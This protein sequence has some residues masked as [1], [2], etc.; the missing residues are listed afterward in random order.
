V[1]LCAY[2]GLTVTVSDGQ[3]AEE[4]IW[5]IIH[6]ESKVLSYPEAQVDY[7]TEQS[8]K[9]CDYYAAVNK[10]SYE[11]A[12]VALELTEEGMLSDAK[13]LVAADMIE[14]A[15][16]KDAGIA[17]TDE[18]KEKYFDKYAEKYAYDWGYNLADVEENR[19][20]E[21]YGIMLYD[22]TTEYLLKHNTFV[23]AQ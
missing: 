3:T 15:L 2:S 18:E 21:V 12:L 8:R 20:E 4:A 14:M 10:V 22:K 16:R 11:E 7:Y 5:Q 1:E 9:R 13:A 19:R 6:S 17:L 23:S